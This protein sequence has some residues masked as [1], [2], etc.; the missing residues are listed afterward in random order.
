[1]ATGAQYNYCTKLFLENHVHLRNFCSPVAPSWPRETGRGCRSIFPLVVEKQMIEIRDL[2]P[3]S[4]KGKGSCL[5]GSCTCSSRRPLIQINFLCFLYNR[6]LGA[7][8]GGKE[9]G[10]GFWCKYMVILGSIEDLLPFIY[11]TKV[12]CRQ[13]TVYMH[14][15]ISKKAG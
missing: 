15:L 14:G 6:S 5:F 11:I 1:M 12:L 2:F 10:L 13:A 7:N 3:Q 9:G 8:L 4:H